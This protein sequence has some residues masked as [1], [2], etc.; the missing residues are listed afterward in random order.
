MTMKTA[1]KRLG[2]IQ[3]DLRAIIFFADVV[4]L[5]VESCASG[6]IAGPA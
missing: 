5:V 6:A 4:E 2:P 3:L 1:I